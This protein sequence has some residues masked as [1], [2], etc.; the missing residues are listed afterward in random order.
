MIEPGSFRDPTAR[1]FYDGDRVLRGL[2]AD[3]AE[4]DRSARASGIMKALTD[5]GLF[6]ESWVAQDAVAPVGVPNA[7]IIESRRI[8]VISYPSEWSFGMLKRAALVT[9]EANLTALD[10]GY[11]LK[12]ASAFNVAFDG[13]EPRILD[14]S[15]LEPFGEKGIWTAY[16]QFCDHFLAPLLLDAYAGAPFQGLLAHNT[17]GL[18]ITELSRMLRGR[19]GL[20]RGVLS[21]V[22]LRSMLERRTASLDTA[23][24]S[25]IGRL[26]LPKAAVVSRIK[27]MKALV[28]RLESTAP[29]TWSGY[30]AAL[31]YESSEVTAK[32]AF[33]RNAA[34]SADHRSMA[35]DVGAN[36][37]RFT[38]LLA[39]VFDHVV[40]IDND[41][42][43][44]DALFR[45]ASDEGLV[46]LTPM[47]VDI[48]N[49]P[50]AFGWRGRERKA[51]FDRVRPTFAT[52]LAVV[53]HLCLSVGVPLEEVLALVY[54]VSDESVVEFVSAEDPMARHISATRRS[55]LAP[56]TPDVF[57]HHAS[58]GGTIVCSEQVSATRTLYHL[59][60]S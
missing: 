54:E 16:G 23:A 48:T 50:Q 60:R 45:T 11:I 6:V 10:G 27:K 22:R 3:A 59:K 53:H 51:F 7:A 33:V 58:A 29:S 43:A 20:H 28:A 52:W 17:E 13:L 31:P 36:A 14:V 55:S 38:R 4:A 41:Q 32:E 46:G 37:G 15:S 26:M 30:E 40:A 5:R 9:L 24:R 21:H 42:G 56:Y 57:E 1:V 47:V 35:L 19:A 44:I 12:D 34:A 8:P 25:D 39:A 18:R 49:P 2:S